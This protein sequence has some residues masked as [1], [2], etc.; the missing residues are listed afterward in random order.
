MTEAFNLTANPL[1]LKWGGVPPSHS[2]TVTICKITFKSS[3][4][5]GTWN[6]T[7]GSLQ[8]KTFLFFLPFCP[9]PL[10]MYISLGV[11]CPP[12]LS[13]CLLP[14][15]LINERTLGSFMPWKISDLIWEDW[16]LGLK[17]EVFDT[18]SLL[19]SDFF[20][21]CYKNISISLWEPM[22]S[23]RIQWNLWVCGN[24]LP[25]GWTGNCLSLSKCY[26]NVKTAAR[27]FP[28]S[29]ITV[30]GRWAR[31]EKMLS[32]SKISKWNFTN[33]YSRPPCLLCC[34]QAAKKPVGFFQRL[35]FH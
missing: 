19:L 6:L 30:A 27:L 28:E 7:S 20:A 23:T 11:T 24:V 34:Q 14:C 18:L 32:L 17:T 25:D 22:A 13:D 12:S 3:S 15:L 9:L 8:L 5:L 21:Y 1:M 29:L 10:S 2:P 26:C 31:K 4:V 35:S 33:V 16:L